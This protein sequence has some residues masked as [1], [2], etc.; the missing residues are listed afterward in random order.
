M[1]YL[2]AFFFSPFVHYPISVLFPVIMIIHE[3]L[4]ENCGLGI[5][6]DNFNRLR[7]LL[8]P[9]ILKISANSQLGRY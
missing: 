5:L 1:Y 7:H 8:K 6:A 3:R 4:S 9:N 2:A